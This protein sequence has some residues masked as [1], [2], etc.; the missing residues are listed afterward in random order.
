MVSTGS[1]AH[2]AG[3]TPN[4]LIVQ[5]TFIPGADLLKL[6]IRRDGVSYAIC[7]HPAASAAAST[8]AERLKAQGTAAAAS[9]KLTASQIAWARI[10]DSEIVFVEDMSAN[11][12]RPL[13]ETGLSKWD[14]AAARVIDFADA[15]SKD[16]SRG[17][18]LIQCYEFVYEIYRDQNTTGLRQRFGASRAKEAANISTPL[19]N[20]A[21]EHI[22]SHSQ[23]PLIIMVFTDGHPGSGESMEAAVKTIL[24]HL[25]SPDQIRIVFFQ[26]GDDQLGTAMMHMLDEDL[27]YVG[28]KDDIVD[29]VKFEDLQESGVTRALL[30]A[31][32][33]PRAVGKTTP[34]LASTALTTKLE[35]VRKQIAAAH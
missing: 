7:L 30:D 19:E 1:A 13:G 20:I 23:K 35:Q 22:E 29:Y 9:P 2:R 32:E 17:F 24:E 25:K 26:I 15:L 3:L 28:Y 21:L 33:R 11:M 8:A 16:T 4:D 5:S 10:K 34:P 14:W 6:T 27:T 12:K 31:Y 18:T